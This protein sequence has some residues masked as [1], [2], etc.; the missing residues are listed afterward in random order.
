MRKQKC[1]L[2]LYSHFLM[3]NQSRYSGTELSKTA[4]DRDIAHDSVSRWLLTS[5]YCPSDLWNKVQN[6]VKPKTG[7]LVLDDTILDKKYSNC[8]EL[9]HYQYSGNQHG[10]VYGIGLVNLLWTDTNSFV[11]VDY[12][13]YDKEHDN[14]TKNDHFKEMIRQ[15][16]KRGFSPLYVLMDS[17]YSGTSNLKLINSLDWHFICSLKSNR[18]IKLCSQ[19]DHISISGLNM[20]EGKV[21]KVWLKEYG[22][23][24]VCKLVTKNGDITYLATNDLALTDYDEFIKHWKYRWNIEDFHRGIK[25]TTGIEKCYS[26]KSNSQRTHIFAAM[27]AF[28]KFET[29]RIRTNVSW[30]EQKLRI[31][32]LAT[33]I[34]LY[35][36]A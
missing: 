22:Y 20:T 31:G 29:D 19:N 10:L 4:S 15:A 18:K 24:L 26:T 21:I 30:Y 25:Q 5:E 35:S 34:Y 12:C 33:Q 23:V 28:V 7:Y 8:N 1:N 13:F 9:A 14:K 16:Y 3:A 6:I 11:P 32:R 17:W 27:V 36:I 2:K